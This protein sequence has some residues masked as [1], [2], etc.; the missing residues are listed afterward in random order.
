MRMIIAE[1]M[2]SEDVLFGTAMGSACFR[3]LVAGTRGSTEPEVLFLDFAGIAVATVSFLREG[4]LAYRTL[5]RTQ[6]STLYPVFANLAAP[7]RDSL[8]DYLKSTRDALFD[9]QLS[10]SGEVTDVQLLGQLDPKQDLTFR[11]TRELGEVTATQLAKEHGAADQ[12][13][14]TAWNN[15]LAA[16]AAKGLLV[17]SQRGRGK[18]FRLTLEVG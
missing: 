8:T 6:R 17:E 1:L 3:D 5:L 12:V 14:V 15:R 16:L 18:S 13:G 7:V 9:C 10:E 2:E 11:V 4:P